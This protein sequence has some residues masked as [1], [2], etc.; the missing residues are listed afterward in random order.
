MNPD[1]HPIIV[2]LV[3]C[4]PVVP[5]PT[6]HL[7]E[8]RFRS[9]S[10]TPDELRYLRQ[11]FD[12]DVPVHDMAD[13]L[14]RGVAGVADRIYTLGLRRH[15][16]RPWNDIEDAEL[17][18]RYGAESAARIASDL[19][20][21]CGATY[22]RASLLG[23]TQGNPPPWSA[24]ED[25]Q[26]RFGYETG[27]ETVQIAAIIGRP[28]SGLMSR[29]SKLGL[30]HPSWSEDWSADEIAR[31]LTL[32]DAGHRYA[33][34]RS[35]LA[36]EGFP[37]RTKPA[38]QNMMNRTGEGKGWGRF[39]TT[40]EDELLIRAYA[41][42]TSLTPLQH[43]LGRSKFSIHWRAEYLKLR[44]THCHRSG[45]RTAPDWTAADEDQL[46]RDY[47]HVPT[48]QLARQM[49]RTR[50]SLTTRANLLGLVHGFIRPWSEPERAALDIAFHNGV[51]ISDLAVALSRKL[52]AVHKYATKHGY[53]FGRRARAD[54]APALNAI[55][56][57]GTTSAA[58]AIGGKG[59]G[60][61]DCG[62]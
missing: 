43:L 24:W 55:L 35:M 28:H 26:L 12:A 30:R 5:R 23:L 15:T 45:W 39:W 34:I 60:K 61:D 20:R 2:E 51:A 57:L 54:P 44:G 7:G 52:A 42:G 37:Q 32:S 48:E 29:A 14:G 31:A 38:F 36:S 25:A 62:A 21:S 53:A 16:T 56:E 59:E 58:A 33:R 17:I 47:G 50:A 8:L 46:R 4:P 18:R 3:A 10:W 19:G 1:Q 27:I 22:A 40:E 9:S 11:M 6:G 41:T 49:G 13:R